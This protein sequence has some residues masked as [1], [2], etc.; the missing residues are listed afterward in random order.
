MKQR[1]IR[2]LLLK[3]SLDRHNRG[4]LVVARVLRDAGMEVIYLEAS[5]KVGQKE[6][7]QVAMQEDVDII[8]V[9]ILSGSPRSI[10]AKLL[11]FRDEMEL[12]DIPV[13]AG[14]IFPE[15]EIDELKSIGISEIF[16][17]GTPTDDI[18]NAVKNIAENR[19]QS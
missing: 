17:P 7:M 15:D 6:M 11:R 4:V 9:S 16:R 12:N 5:P 1:R 18:V 2:V 3:P 10:L 8:G 13:I 14:G 19:L